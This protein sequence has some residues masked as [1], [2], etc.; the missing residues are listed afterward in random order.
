MAPVVLERLRGV[1]SRVGLGDLSRRLEEVTALAAGDLAT[2]ELVLQEVGSDAT[3][4]TASAR[5]LIQHS[6]KRLR[7][8][9]VALAARM[10]G[11]FGAP[12]RELAVAVE[13]VH[14]ATLLHDDVVDLGEVRRGAPAARILYGNAASIFAG[15]WLLVEALRRVER[16]GVPNALPRL[17][18]V[19][20]EMILAESLQLDRRGRLSGDR[21]SYQRV[22]EGKTA[23]L[24]RWAFYAG[25]RAGGLSEAVTSALEG[26][27]LHLGAAF[28]VIDDVLD[29]GG[30]E[31]RVGKTL[32]A[33]LRE[34][35]MTLPLIFALERD[36]S[37]K[38]LLEE[39]MALPPERPVP[40]PLVEQVLA[41]LRAT[42]G[43]EDAREDARS[44]VTRALRCLEAVPPSPASQVLAAVAEATLS[45]QS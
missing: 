2:V 20:E 31:P 38:G 32:F 14:T 37:M 39:A 17:L 24:F 18:E 22:V 11:G 36:P 27:G 21:D 34:G 3:S 8:L 9:C 7:P 13:L 15:D 45:R 6:G 12:A 5:Y 44:R 4:V 42:R 10:G 26:F 29:F 23:S 25:A 16:S 40:S 19:I 33:D 28:Q 41:V 1:S 30:Q 35:K 43:I